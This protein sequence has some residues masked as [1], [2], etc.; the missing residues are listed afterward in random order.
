MVTDAL[1]G[2][3]LLFFVIKNILYAKM[4]TQSINVVRKVCDAGYVMF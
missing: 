1:A 2:F 3:C 4:S